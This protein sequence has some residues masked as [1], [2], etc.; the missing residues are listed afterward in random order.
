MFAKHGYPKTFVT[1]L[2]NIYGNHDVAFTSFVTVLLLTV[3]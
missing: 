2:S 1:H 3:K